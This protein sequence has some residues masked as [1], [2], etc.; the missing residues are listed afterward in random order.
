MRG[1]S[2]RVFKLYVFSLGQPT[3]KRVI[4][5]LSGPEARPSACLCRRSSFSLYSSFFCCSFASLSPFHMLATLDLCVTPVSAPVRKE[6]LSPASASF[7]WCC[8]EEVS[9]FGGGVVG[10]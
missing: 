9:R 1:E 2:F 4:C 10:F 3:L 7:V 6:R 8:G 5:I